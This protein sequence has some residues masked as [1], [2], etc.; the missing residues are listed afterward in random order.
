MGAIVLLVGVIG[1]GVVI[2][3]VTVYAVTRSR[4]TS[5]N[6]GLADGAY[7]QYVGYPPR[8]PMPFAQQSYPTSAPNQGY[9]YPGSSAQLP[10][11]PNPYAQQPPYQG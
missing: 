8:Q 4:R 3:A 6:S 2:A 7:P 10:Q 11:H 9:G 5:M 1:L